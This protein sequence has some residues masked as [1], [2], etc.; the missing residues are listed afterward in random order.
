MGQIAQHFKTAPLYVVLL[1]TGHGTT[2]EGNWITKELDNHK[3]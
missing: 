3:F 1:Y 2:K